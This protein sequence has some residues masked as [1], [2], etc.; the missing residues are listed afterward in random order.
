MEVKPL[1]HPPSPI[2]ASLVADV[3]R[4]PDGPPV[5]TTEALTAAP[6]ES[7]SELASG[8]KAE[9]SPQPDPVTL[10]LPETWY[11]AEELDS[12][13]QPLTAVPLRYPPEYLGRGITARARILL[14]VDELGIVRKAAISEATPEPAFGE[15]ALEAWM[16]VR[17]SPA[18]KEGIAVKSRK[19]VEIDFQ[20][21]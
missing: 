6:E 17:F 19:L 5:A 21:N 15:A 10:P 7:Q 12:R 3:E 9:A 14:H 18:M 1:A 13:A 8:A 4:R 2:H 20:P 16:D 11:A